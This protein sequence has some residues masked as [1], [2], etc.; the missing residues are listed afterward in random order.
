M[1]NNAWSIHQ[2]AACRACDATGL[3]E[4][5]AF[6][7]LPFTD[8]F[9]APNSAADSEFRHRLGISWCPACATV[10]TR[11][12]V[13]VSEYYRDYR[14][15]VAGSPFAMQFMDRL[16]QTTIERFGLRK[17]DVVLEIGS[18][19]GEQL[20][21]FQRRGCRVLGFEPSADLTAASHASA[22]PAL[23]CL[24]DAES[25]SLIPADMRPAQAVVL[26]Y[27]FDHLPDPVPFLKA[28]HDVLDA[29][30]GVLIVEIHHLGDIVSRAETCLFEHEHS[31]YLTPL[32]VSRMLAR[33]GFTL[34]STT[35]LPDQERRGNSLLFAAAPMGTTQM[36]DESASPSA[37]S[38]WDAFDNVTT[39]TDFAADAKARLGALREYV[40]DARAAGKRIAGY[41]AGGRGVLTIAQAGLTADDI[42]YVCDG[43]TAFHGKLMP[44]SRVPVMPPSH[45][46]ESPVDEV[47]V[48]S[49][50]YLAEIR[51]SQADLEASGV[52]F[53]SLLDL[54]ACATS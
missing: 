11:E 1:S 32:T 24:F 16:A 5:L 45:L 23:Q 13:D 20:A 3:H 27:T 51:R 28:V 41:G 33:A 14:Y 36:A 26:T 21:A 4:F 39:Y 46:R 37:L 7:R 22:V 49:Y 15:T 54:L 53:T 35:L 9:V 19:D 2:R 52:K 25:A 42:E 10:Q 17:D 48:F 31:I 38:V 12:D 40:R 44:A 47:I 6:D 43:N 34:L 8:D 18:G 30:R 50:G 29:K